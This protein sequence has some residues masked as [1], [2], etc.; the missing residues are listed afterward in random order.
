MDLLYVGLMILFVALSVV[1]VLGC[2]KL[3]RRPQ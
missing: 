2:D 1:L 3:P